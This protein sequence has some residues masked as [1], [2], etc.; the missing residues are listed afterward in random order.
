MRTKRQKLTEIHA[1]DIAPRMGRTKLWAERLNL[2][3]PKGAKA[4]IT[5]ALVG[6]EDSLDLA[7]E[8]ISAELVRRGHAALPNPK[9]AKH[10]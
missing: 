3:L 6:D 2:T 1:H 8:A 10:Q 4:Q 7:R 5:A 9:K